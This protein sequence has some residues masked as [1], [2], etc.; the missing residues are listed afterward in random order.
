MRRVLVIIPAYNEEECIAQV[1]SQVKSCLG[2]ADVAV[3]DDGST[4]ATAQRASE[5]NAMV[6]SLPYNL[7]IGGAVQS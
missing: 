2:D 6:L 5:A 7:G 1:V 3:I 4:D